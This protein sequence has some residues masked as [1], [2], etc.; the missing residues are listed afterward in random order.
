[1]TRY[2]PTEFSVTVRAAD[3]RTLR[4]A[5]RGDLDYDT[6]DDFALAMYDTLHAHAEEH[7]PTL[8]DLHLDWA[9]LNAFDSS[10]LSALLGLRRRAHSAGISLHLDRRPE[11]L[12]RM[13]QVTGIADHLTQPANRGVPSS[14][15]AIGEGESA[16]MS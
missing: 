9:E 1:M 4:V 10:G 12:V 7:G 11:F 8:R 16:P 5:V 3:A 2:Q 14:S 13:L 15:P 6:S